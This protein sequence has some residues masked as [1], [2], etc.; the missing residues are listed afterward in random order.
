M[1]S[2]LKNYIL[3]VLFIVSYSCAQAEIFYVLQ[4]KK[5][6]FC[7]ENLVWDAKFFS[8][9][10]Q[11]IQHIKVIAEQDYSCL[12]YMDSQCCAPGVIKWSGALNMGLEFYG[13]LPKY[14]GALELTYNSY[15]VICRLSRYGNFYCE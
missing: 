7:V 9:N 11:A 5:W 1:D 10:Q 6:R 3:P 12:E 4:Q 8:F 2:N 13:G 15:K 14:N